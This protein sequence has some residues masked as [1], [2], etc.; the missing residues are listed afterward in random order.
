MNAQKKAMVLVF[1]QNT[2]VFTVLNVAR[3][4]LSLYALHMGAGATEVGLVVALLYMPSLFFSLP[5]GILAD[6][7]GSRWL[8]VV[9]SAITA[10]GMLVPSL[11]PTVTALC[12]GSFTVGISLSV[13]NVL[14]Q[15]LVGQLSTPAQ[16]MR[17]FGNYALV[18]ALS[19]LVGPLV[20]GFVIDHAGFP[21]ACL[22]TMA[23]SA[24]AAL[25]ALIWGGLLPRGRPSP[26]GGVN[27]FASLQSPEVRR[28]LM[29]SSVAQIGFDSFN[30]FMPVYAHG[31]GLSA[32]AIGVALSA[33]AVAS[34]GMRVV[35]VRLAKNW[36]EET[37]MAG[38]FVCGAVAFFLL[39]AF[40]LVAAISAVSFVFGVFGGLTQPIAMMMLYNASTEGRA[41]EAMGLRITINNFMRVLGPTVFGATARTFG[42]APLFLG[43]GALMLFAAYR[44]LGRRRPSAP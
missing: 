41:G 32:S 43:S 28:I 33:F 22:M 14:G 4:A 7:H 8:F 23:L 26:P 39:P 35:I 15:N 17:N 38:G 1:A 27:I 18:G 29:L 40:K 12:I 2:I 11:W 6:R 19:N 21:A 5:A 34:L 44:S 10:A 31:I 37:I 36:R 16:R 13:S 24:I 20:V 42:L 30:S 9:S 25:L 3:I